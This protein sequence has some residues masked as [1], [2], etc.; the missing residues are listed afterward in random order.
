M[1]NTI[2][3]YGILAAAILLTIPLISNLFMGS[4]PDN[5]TM[6]EVVGYSSMILSLLLIFV[7]QNEYRKNSPEGKIAF[8]KGLLM[9]LAISAL[10]SFGFAIY[11]W[12]YIEF[13]N[14]DFIEQYYSYY[15]E[16]IKNSGQEAA[17]I[18]EKISQLE[19]EKA[20]FTSPMVQF[21]VMYLTVFAVG[22]VVSLITAAIS[23]NLKPAHA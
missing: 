11:N 10:A 22:I 19:G 2:F 1:K 16:S 21:A 4:N 12:V 20:F 23:S 3:K 9:G 18:Q 6:G 5:Y 15:V 14:P 17:V 7:A 8:G 13:I